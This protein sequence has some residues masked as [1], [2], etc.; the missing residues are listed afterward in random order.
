MITDRVK[1]ELVKREQRSW[2]TASW[3]INFSEAIAG[4]H[5][6]EMGR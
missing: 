6:A 4:K 5:N 3:S 1:E 2:S